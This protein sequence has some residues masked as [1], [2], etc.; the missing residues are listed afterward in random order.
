MQ[1][2][3][4]RSLAMMAEKESEGISRR[5]MLSVLLAAPALSL[6]GGEAEAAEEKQVLRESD[7]LRR[8]LSTPGTN[9]NKIFV[10]GSGKDSPAVQ[11]PA[12]VK[13]L[14]S[15]SQTKSGLYYKV[16]K[17]GN[18]T[19]KSP[20]KGDVVELH[21]IGSACTAESDGT[22]ECSER[23]S[24]PE[25]YPSMPQGILKDSPRFDSS[26]DRG[27]T[28][29]VRYGKAQLTLGLEEA[30]RDMKPGGAKL[31]F[32]VPELAYACPPGKMCVPDIEANE[33]LAF[34]IELISVNEI[35]EV[36]G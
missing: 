2:M 6:L 35:N 5:D 31:V 11:F 17:V 23:E 34:Y 12:S 21:Y 3:E 18:E 15:Y 9:R 32:L 22:Y 24:D 27:R 25:I 14:E 10:K 29:K 20:Q 8:G 30:M 7:R 28:M 4:R 19:L 26:F 16:L 1:R 33:R 13:D 36:G